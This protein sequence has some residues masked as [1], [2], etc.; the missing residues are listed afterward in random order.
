VIYSPDT[1]LSKASSVQ[2]TRTFHPDLP[3]C[4]EASNC[5][6]LHSFGCFSST[7]GQ[8]SVLDQLRDFFP[9]HRYG[10][11][12]ATIQT[13][14]IPVRTRSSIREVAHSKFRCPDTSLHGPDVRA[15]YMEIACIR[16]TVWTI[17]PMVWTRE[18][19]I[20]RIEYLKPL[21][22]CAQLFV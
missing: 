11:I 14:W 16:S 21:P 5:F 9:K 12:V 2:T 19:L 22:V 17:F 15:T 6:S 7:S 13:M 18:A 8:H 3:L 10:K 1:Q 20:W 4:Q